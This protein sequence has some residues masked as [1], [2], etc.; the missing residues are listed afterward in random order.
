MPSFLAF[1]IVLSLVILIHELG[2]FLAAKK[3]GVKVEEF[4]FGYPPRAW[5]KKI[6][7]TIYSINWLPF[8]G[9]VKLF[10][11]QREGA[12][13]AELAS[14][15]AF[16]NQGKKKR[17]VVI[18]A[19]IAANFLLGAVCFSLVYSLIG[20]PKKVD[21]V[22]VDY[23]VSN[24]PAEGAGIRQGDKIVKVL[25]KE[26]FDVKQF[27]DLMDERRE[28]ETEIVIVSKIKGKFDEKTQRTARVT[29]RR[30]PPE[31]EGALGILISNYDNIFHP[32]WQMPFR[33]AWVGIQEAVG[34]GI[35]MLLGVV[36]M[37]KQLFTGVIPEVTGPIGI[38]QITSGVASQG[39]LALTKFIGILSINL[40]VVN[41]L[42]FPALDGGWLALV[43]LEK[44]IGRKLKPGFEYWINAVGMVLLIGL[45]IAIT[46]NDVIRVIKN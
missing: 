34:W 16:V 28:I 30:D 20:I 39:I 14:P 44:A 46:A 41:L 10:G 24:S 6:G 27:V 11:Q 9:F 45:M 42:P 3:A 19:G 18:I 8:G 22:V 15:R 38:Y 5:G 29:P 36:Q 31:D 2:H 43:F 26:I 37:V 1:L 13:N 17:A 4:G 7:E 35:A 32:F 40:A 23:V 12:T 33:G 21:Y 25:D